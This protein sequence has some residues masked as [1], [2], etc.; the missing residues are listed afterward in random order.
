[1]HTY[2]VVT[3]TGSRAVNS[4]QPMCPEDLETLRL[5]FEQQALPPNKTVELSDKS[6]QQIKAITLARTGKLPAEEAKRYLR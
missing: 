1:M 6:S 3:G 5:I 2:T 4:P